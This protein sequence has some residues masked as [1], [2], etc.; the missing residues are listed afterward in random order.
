MEQFEIYCVL[1]QTEHF[2]LRMSV[3]VYTDP[4]E[5]AAAAYELG[6]AHKCKT[7]V[8]GFPRPADAVANE[9]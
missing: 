1:M 8:M 4:D 5:A 6:R 2:G 7:W 9:G 3:K